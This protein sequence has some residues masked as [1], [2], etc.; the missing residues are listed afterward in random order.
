[1][2]IKSQIKELIKSQA[3]PKRSEMQEL[4]DLILQLMPKCKQWYFD[5]KNEDG[6]Q[7]AHPTIG[8]GEYIITYKDRTVRDFFRIGLLA[9]PTGLAVHIMGLDDKKFLIDNYG[10]TIGKAKVSSYGIAFKSI[11]DINLEV[12]KEAIRYRA[13]LKN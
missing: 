10:K 5:G 3:E 12:L 8:Y 2:E 13:V 11:K 7:V 9:S 1:M 4:H 6:K